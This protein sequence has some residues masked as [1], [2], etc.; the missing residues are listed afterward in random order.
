MTKVV[1]F[2]KT[3]DRVQAKEAL[4][5]LDQAFA[6]YD[7]ADEVSAGAAIAAVETPIEQMYGYYPAA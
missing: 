5:V 2:V 3:A 1:K 6:Y 4:N 7:C